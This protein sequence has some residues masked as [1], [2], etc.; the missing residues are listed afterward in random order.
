[1]KVCFILDSEAGKTATSVVDNLAALINSV[2]GLDARILIIRTTSVF[3]TM[4]AFQAIRGA[5][6]VVVHSA[7][8]TRL[9]PLLIARVLGRVTLGLVWDVYPVTIAGKLFDPSFKGRLLNFLEGVSAKLCSGLIVPTRDFLVA[10]RYAKASYVRFWAPLY[11]DAAPPER[12]IA[13][14]WGDGILRI[15]FAGQINQTR[16]LASAYREICAKAIE[17]VELVV[18]SAD[19]LPAE[20]EQD[21]RVRHV[22]YLDQ[23]KLASM[24]AECDL[25]LVCINRDFDGPAFPSKIG[26]YAA[27]SLPIL[28]IGPD[29]FHLRNLIRESR[30][31]AVIDDLE[32]ISKSLALN[33][34]ADM[35]KSVVRFEGQTSAD[36]DEL[37]RY[38]S[39]IKGIGC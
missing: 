26:A 1:M 24:M 31:G 38:L 5:D 2:E 20:L 13:H 30:V 17:E 9:F 3:D 25:G 39:S 23:G 15:I 11:G 36:R 19:P 8:G 14:E 18:A 6:L 28:F 4:R 22:G 29:L 21:D 12:G 34:K 33:L 35:G 7:L 16:G 32:T 10:G 27:A 37:Q